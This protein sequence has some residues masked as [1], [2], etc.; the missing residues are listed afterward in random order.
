MEC[1]ALAGSDKEGGRGNKREDKKIQRKNILKRCLKLSE[2]FTKH[3]QKT[4][5]LLLLQLAKFASS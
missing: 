4:L 2:G 3:F 5:G 1:V